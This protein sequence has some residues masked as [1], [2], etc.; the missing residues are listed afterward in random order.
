[1]SQLNE[2]EYGSYYRPYIIT[3]VENGKGLIENM[4]DSLKDILNTL[5]KIP[6]TKQ[7]YKYADGKWTIKELVQH[8]ID[9]ERVFSYRA[10]RFARKDSTDLPGF[11]QDEFNVM[12]NANSRNFK[13][14]LEELFLVRKS[15]ISLFKSIDSETLKAIGTASGSEMSVRAIGYIISGHSLHH[16]KVLKE[17]YLQ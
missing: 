3:M 6:E 8:I 16:L 13:E 7:L 12:A 4:N 15:S 1:M 5:N 9:T 17:R 14:L 10:L 2:N 11:D